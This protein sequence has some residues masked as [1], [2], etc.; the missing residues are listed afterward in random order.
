MKKIDPNNHKI[1]YGCQSIIR[2]DVG[3]CPQCHAYR[4]E[5]EPGKV[6]RQIRLIRVKHQWLKMID[7]VRE[8]IQEWQDWV[9]SLPGGLHFL[10]SQTCVGRLKIGLLNQRLSDCEANLKMVLS[11][12][13]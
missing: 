7:D 11:E 13:L 5:D 1:C 6:D 2:K 8:E 3:V 10:D 4:F 9:D 12:L